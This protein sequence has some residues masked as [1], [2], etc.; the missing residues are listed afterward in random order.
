MNNIPTSP[1]FVQAAMNA[2]NILSSYT[3]DEDVKVY[4]CTDEFADF[5]KIVMLKLLEETEEE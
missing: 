2:W 4:D 3:D 1:D 5:Y